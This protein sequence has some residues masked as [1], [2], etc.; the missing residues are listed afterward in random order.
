[1]TDKK[2]ISD[3]PDHDILLC[4]ISDLLKVYNDT[5]AGERREIKDMISEALEK[6]AE[7]DHHKFVEA[8]M[9]RE[10]RKQEMWEKI[11]TQVLAWG[12]IGVAGFLVIALWHEFVAIMGDAFKHLFGIKHNVHK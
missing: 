3:N 2:E 7:S 8:M 5:A 11:K 6:H 4:K 10:Q 1:M 9:I 12:A